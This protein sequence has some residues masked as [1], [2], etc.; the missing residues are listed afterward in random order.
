MVRTSVMSAAV[1]GS[2]LLLGAVLSAGAGQA[3][4]PAARPAAAQDPV[5]V[6]QQAY[7]IYCASC[8]GPRAQGTGTDM[9]QNA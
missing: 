7:A 1:V 8:H 3:P 6:G 9:R 5:A 4:G 2:A